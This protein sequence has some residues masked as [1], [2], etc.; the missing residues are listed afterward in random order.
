M[1][2]LSIRPLKTLSPEH[3]IKFPMALMTRFRMAPRGSLSKR[4]RPARPLV[5]ALGRLRILCIQSFCL[6]LTI[7]AKKLTL[8]RILHT[9]LPAPQ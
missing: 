7:S 3:A 9:H 8:S 5:W 1:I 6:F 4:V 2:S